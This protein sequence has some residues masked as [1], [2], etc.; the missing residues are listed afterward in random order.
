[1]KYINKILFFSFIACV[2]D[3]CFSKT[4]IVDDVTDTANIANDSTVSGCILRHAVQ[5][6]QDGSFGPM[7]NGKYLKFP[8]CGVQDAM[9]PP[10]G[11]NDTIVLPVGTIQ[12]VQSMNLSKKMTIR[13]AFWGVIKNPKDVNSIVKAPQGPTKDRVFIT[14][15]EDINLL[16]VG[17]TGGDISGESSGTGGGGLWAKGGGLVTFDLCKIYGNKALRGGGILI[18]NGEVRLIKSIVRENVATGTTIGQLPQLSGGGGIAQEGG[19]L[20]IIGTL[21]TIKPYNG[22]YIE[23]R[24]DTSA[25]N[26][27]LPYYFYQSIGDVFNYS[28]F[29][30]NQSYTVGSQLLIT[31]GTTF[32]SGTHFDHGKAISPAKIN[33]P[34]PV[35]QGT[36][37]VG[38]GNRAYFT[39]NVFS[40][41][42][43]FGMGSGAYITGSVNDVSFV[44]NTFLGNRNIGWE[45]D[46]GSGAIAVIRVDQPTSASSIK[47]LGNTFRQNKTAGA[48]IDLQRVGSIPLT[49]GNNLFIENSQLLVNVFGIATD[50]STGLTSVISPQET[51]YITPLNR[52][53][54]I[55]I[56]GKTSAL[57][58]IIHNTFFNEVGQS[59]I[60]FF[61]INEVITPLIAG[62][63]FYRDTATAFKNF[64]NPGYIYPLCNLADQVGVF[65]D[66]VEWYGI[67]AG[68]PVSTTATCVNP[69]D[70][71]APPA[72]QQSIILDLYNSNSPVFYGPAGGVYVQLFATK[73]NSL[74]RSHFASEVKYLDQ[75]NKPRY[76]VNPSF[77]VDGNT[78]GS[79][80]LPIL[81]PPV[82]GN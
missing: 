10:F 43:V 39:K 37:W 32:V 51:T 14:G 68:A 12:L 24:V 77:G 46:D 47:I 4:I 2:S 55:E 40:Y 33:F 66:N 73:Y 6:I 82:H 7:Q 18:T 65:R 64:P 57:T 63:I 53:I 56:N 59:N 50:S 8:K 25:L 67:S 38:G 21:E 13:G 31:G 28:L 11:V 26:N 58:K 54:S 76:I 23:T 15:S 62:N 34:D 74:F 69:K 80:E 61:F 42:D 79:I 41:N 27:T 5:A 16:G 9:S 71:A 17:I 3:I 20:F 22:D 48:V 72:D 30:N 75:L 81:P 52:P 1:M 35:R 78:V 19:T 36:V 49:I 60:S 44:E 45:E 70:P 29:Y